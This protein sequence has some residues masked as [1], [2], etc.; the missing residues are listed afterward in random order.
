M[1]EEEL[2]VTKCIPDNNVNQMQRQKYQIIVIFWTKVEVTK[3]QFE[4]TSPIASII[5][6]MDCLWLSCDIKI[7]ILVLW[8][9]DRD[10]HLMQ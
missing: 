4:M 2:G 5:I 7:I 1:K 6:G 10:E 3:N 9:P 8:N